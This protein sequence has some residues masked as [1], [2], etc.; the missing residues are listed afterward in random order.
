[1]RA[2]IYLGQMT[3]HASAEDTVDMLE[4]IQRYGPIPPL[5]GIRWENLAARLV[6]DKKTVQ[7]KV[8]FVLPVRIGEVTVV[9]G[10]EEKRVADAIRSALAGGR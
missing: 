10:V 5:D 3:G 8:H 6:H 9:S 4:L 1:M 7:G 2:A